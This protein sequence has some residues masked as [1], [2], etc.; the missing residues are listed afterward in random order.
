MSAQELPISSLQDF[1]R[2]KGVTIYQ[3]IRNSPNEGSKST[4]IKR[5]SNK[6]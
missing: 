4:S 3:S 1:S 2:R 6:G 5:K